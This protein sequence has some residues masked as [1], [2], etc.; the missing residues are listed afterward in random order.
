MNLVTLATSFPSDNEKIPFL[1]F[2]S[3]PNSLTCIRVFGDRVMV[4]SSVKTMT[5][6]APSPVTIKSF[7]L[8]AELTTGR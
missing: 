8:T 4:L 1:S 7:S 5:A 6:E 3:M 2:P